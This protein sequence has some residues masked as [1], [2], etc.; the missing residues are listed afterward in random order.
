MA[1]YRTV[2][3]AEAGAAKTS[4]ATTAKP[5]HNPR[6]ERSLPST[7]IHLN[8]ATRG[9]SSTQMERTPTLNSEA[10]PLHK[11]GKRG[12]DL[13]GLVVEEARQDHRLH[14]WLHPL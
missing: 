11:R 1:T 4:A 9:L 12:R 10:A 5:A 2:V 6:A 7:G 8:M 14:A 13:V 3:A